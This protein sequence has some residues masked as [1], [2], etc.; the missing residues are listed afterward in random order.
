MSEPQP[1]PQKAVQ[2]AYCDTYYP[3]CGCYDDSPP[4]SAADAIATGFLVGFL[5]YGVY[6]I[7]TAPSPVPD[8]C[9]VTVLAD[10]DEDDERRDG[11]SRRSRRMMDTGY[12]SMRDGDMLRSPR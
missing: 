4:G 5:F 12:D 11:Y 8:V 10:D 1:Q 3:R 9:Y 7:L 6:Y 2:E